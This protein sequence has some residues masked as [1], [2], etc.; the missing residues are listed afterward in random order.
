M[1][2]K[3]RHRTTYSYDTDVSFA[4]CVLRLTPRS[5]PTQTVLE[6]EVGKR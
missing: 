3:L 6:S 1:N 2:Y 4:R 5:S